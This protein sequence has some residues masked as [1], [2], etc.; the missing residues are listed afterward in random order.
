MLITIARTSSISW[1]SYQGLVGQKYG[2][3]EPPYMIN[4]YEFECIYSALE[5]HRSRSSRDHDVLKDCYH[6]DKN[7][8]KREYVMTSQAL[9][10]VRG[11]LEK[12]FR[13][14]DVG[15]SFKFMEG[16]VSAFD[17][18]NNFFS[19]FLRILLITWLWYWRYVV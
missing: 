12:N 4:R 15:G 2:S 3:S 19:V 18:L 1:I 11:R 13:T 14:Y 8:F 16:N 6:Q 10:V 9:H 5:L 7:S 17:D